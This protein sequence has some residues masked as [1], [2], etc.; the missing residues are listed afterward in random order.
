MT[1]SKVSFKNLSILALVNGQ[2]NYTRTPEGSEVDELASG[3]GETTLL[4]IRD[5][6]T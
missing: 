6:Q 2:G 3:R 5:I 4:L 1:S